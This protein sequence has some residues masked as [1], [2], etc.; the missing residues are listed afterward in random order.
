EARITDRAGGADPSSRHDTDVVGDEE[1]LG[2]LVPTTGGD[3][4]SRVVVHRRSP[5]V[6]ATGGQ[7]ARGVPQ[8]ITVARRSAHTEGRRFGPA[9]RSGGGACACVTHGLPLLRRRRLRR[10]DPWPRRS[11]P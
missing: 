7:T 2:P 11:T 4:P 6:R 1:Q 5:L 3:H 9:L 8:P 10:S